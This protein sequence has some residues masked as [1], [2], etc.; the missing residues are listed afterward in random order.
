VTSSAS[1]ISHAVPSIAAAVCGCATSSKR[2]ASNSSFVLVS[3]SASFSFNCKAASPLSISRASL[4]ASRFAR[5]PASFFKAL[6]RALII[7]PVKRCRISIAIVSAARCWRSAAVLTP[8]RGRPCLR[9]GPPIRPSKTSWS[10]RICGS[11]SYGSP[12]S[13]GL[14][15]RRCNRPSACTWRSCRPRSSCLS[16]SSDATNGAFYNM[17]INNTLVRIE[18]WV[19]SVDQPR[20][21]HLHRYV[22]NYD[23]RHRADGGR[24]AARSI[25]LKSVQP[26]VHLAFVVPKRLG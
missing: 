24:I 14:P 26:A 21:F 25:P 1:G 13:W 6:S 8:V 5:V 18:N 4:T 23:E 20:I 16:S 11:E 2:V 19:Q 22:V 9:P 10:A 7:L 12:S 15:P 3:K 17:S